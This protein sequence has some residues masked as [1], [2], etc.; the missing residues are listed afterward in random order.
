M[1]TRIERH[2]V[3][4]VGARCAG[5]ATAMLL[6]R[7]GHDVV[8]LDRS[9]FP[10]DT[11]STHGIAR[12]GVVQLAR[13]GL[14]DQ[15]HESG[16][17]AVREVL[18]RLG[19]AQTVRQIKR[20]A[21]VDHLVAP[22]RYALDGLLQDAAVRAGAT[23][24]TGVTVT[25]VRRRGVGRVVGSDG[26]GPGGEPVTVEA[27]FVIGADGVRSR[28]A[29][30]LGAEVL[31]SSPSG[32]GT[33]YTYVAD[34]PLE[35][36]S[37]AYEFHVARD[38]FAGIFP[39]HH[40]VSCVWLGAPTHALGFLDSPGPDRTA[41]LLAAIGEASPSLAERVRAGRVE[42]PVRGRA[43]LPN[44]V[45]RPIG[46][47][48]PGGGSQGWALVGDAGYH[49][50]PVTGHGIT[51]AFRDAELLA[52]AVDTA[53]RAGDAGC[54]QDALAAYQVRRD[55]ALRETFDITRAL[56]AFPSPERFVELQIQ[57][58]EALEREAADLAAQPAP[59]GTAA[60]AA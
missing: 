23:L 14:L 57:L 27:D 3:A 7:A 34:V 21:G 44:I 26:R 29:G 6:A 12:G 32:T 8:L 49:R 19:E 31:E 42:A 1:G 25:G 24:R 47:R 20:R 43:G 38:A 41:A 5:A 30:W 10:S 28:M 56:S 53:L 60:A 2:Q 52:N 54:E 22:R 39:T 46:R 48:L 58:S 35:T 37:P 15:V 17:P 16:A 33:F 40:G 55:T 45:R 36:R 11:V 51:D 59:L 4:V 50:D 13:W 18:F 9:P